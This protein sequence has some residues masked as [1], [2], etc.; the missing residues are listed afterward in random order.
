MIT[1]RNPEKGQAVN[2]DVEA[3]KKR[4]S[5]V[6]LMVMFHVGKIMIDKW[7]LPQLITIVRPLSDVCCLINP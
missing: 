6:H 4:S 7:I 1:V 3:R 2:A 5:K